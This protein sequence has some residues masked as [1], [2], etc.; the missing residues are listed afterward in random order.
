VQHKEQHDIRE[1]GG[2]ILY[3]LNIVLE[4]VGVNVVVTEIEKL[5]ARSV[6]N[7]SERL[8]E[9]CVLAASYFV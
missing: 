2:D 9:T 6:E 1:V 8:F 7:S 4:D 3:K 5:L